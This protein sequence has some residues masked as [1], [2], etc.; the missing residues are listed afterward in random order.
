MEIA[1]LQRNLHPVSL[2][3]HSKSNMKFNIKA[4]TIHKV[5]SLERDKDNHSIVIVLGHSANFHFKIMIK[6]FYFEN[7]KMPSSN[8]C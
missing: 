1:L 2:P 4:N 8:C 5:L 7:F 6:I 3:S